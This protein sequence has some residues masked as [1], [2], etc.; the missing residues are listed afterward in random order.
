MLKAMATGQIKD[1]LEG[2]N[3]YFNKYPLVTSRK[4]VAG[5]RV[6]ISIKVQ[7]LK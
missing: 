6:C 5:H 4:L 7:Y 2:Y 3:T 1:T